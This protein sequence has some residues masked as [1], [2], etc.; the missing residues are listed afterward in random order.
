MVSELD[1]LLLFFV[2]VAFLYDAFLVEVGEPT[3]SQSY[4]AL[5]PTWVDILISLPVVAVIYFL[6]VHQGIKAILFYLAGHI[7]FPNKE[8]F[9]S[10]K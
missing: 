6:H 7:F 1:L 9:K 4:Q 10:G 5:F 3:I 8:R 2:A